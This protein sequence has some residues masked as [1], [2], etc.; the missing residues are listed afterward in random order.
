MGGSQARSGCRQML[1][2]DFCHFL[3]IAPVNAALLERLT[4]VRKSRFPNHGDGHAI[5]GRKRRI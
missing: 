4:F 2:V 1:G 5:F 3:L